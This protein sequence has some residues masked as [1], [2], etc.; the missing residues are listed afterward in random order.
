MKCHSTKTT[1]VTVRRRTAILIL[2]G[3]LGLELFSFVAGDGKVGDGG[4]ELKYRFSF[5][6]VRDDPDRI[7]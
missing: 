2:D 6:L 4:G 1:H 3:A 7:E 5:K